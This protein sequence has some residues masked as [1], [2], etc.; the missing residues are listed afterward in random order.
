MMIIIDIKPGEWQS[1][2]EYVAGPGTVKFLRH[3]LRAK[4]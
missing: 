1:I 3:Q 4:S 2:I